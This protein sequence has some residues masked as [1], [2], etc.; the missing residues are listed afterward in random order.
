MTRID[1]IK[2]KLNNLLTPEQQQEQRANQ[3]KLN[4]FLG[5]KIIKFDNFI[6]KLN[7]FLWF[8]VSKFIVFLI[9]SLIIF[10]EYTIYF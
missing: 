10:F 8:K 1:A 6:K 5:K 3:E 4:T 2:T 9:I 7:T